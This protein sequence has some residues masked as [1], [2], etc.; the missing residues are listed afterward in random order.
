MF[1]EES[2][3]K[4]DFR[5]AYG[6]TEK[7]N[8]ATLRNNF[9][10]YSGVFHSAARSR[11]SFVLR[12]YQADA[13]E[14]LRASYRSGR[15]APLFV[16][17][18]GGGKTAVFSY[19][20]ENAVSRS[21]RVTILVHRQE[22]LL[23]AS[24]SLARLGVPHGIISPKFSANA[25]AVQVASVQTLARRLD[26]V[27]A[28]D[29]IIVDEAHHATSAS[30]RAVLRAFPNAAILGVTA[31]PCRTDGAGLSD[32]F[33]DLV[34]GPSISEL[35]SGGFLVEP[36]VYA[37]PVGIDLAGVRRKMGDY[38]K[39]ELGDRIDKPSITGD[40]VQHYLRLCGGQPAIAFCVSVQHAEHVAEEFRAAGLRAL[41]VDGTMDDSARRAAIEGLGDGSV[42]V[43]TSADLIGEGVDVPR[44][45]AAI[46]L[47]PTQSTALY[48]QQVGRALRPYEGKSRAIILDHVGN[49]MRHGL[50]D[51]DREWSL[52]GQPRSR[53]GGGD[54]PLVR[55][56]QCAAC[57]FVFEAGP[58]RCPACG[59]QAPI[60]I[61]KIEV[62]EGELRKLTRE[63]IEAAKR[64]RKLEQGKAKTVEELESIGR[65]RGMRFP[66]VWAERVLMGRR[67]A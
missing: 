38:D 34:E 60:K 27:A 39:R 1:K 37:P 61:R 31:T 2:I 7:N 49:T 45:A 62:T 36:V 17:P 59:N 21:K 10:Y 56:E 44:V 6:N 48:L 22:L 16:L 19:I 12:S 65:A 53:R 5:E 54:G 14:K 47:R 25:E 41:R 46:L 9:R 40:A 55:V 23:Q 4:V 51:E 32:V 64:S 50:P 67:R 43:L 58:E 15:R 13:V 33:D 29:L 26:R 24:R 3:E 35:I 8:E 30:Y 11:V 28:P 20:A 66:R 42:D 63:E 57:F 52:D 18:T